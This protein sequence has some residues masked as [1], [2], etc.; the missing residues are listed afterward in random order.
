MIRSPETPAGENLNN[1]RKKN[2]KIF[3]FPSGFAGNK[4]NK[5]KFLGLRGSSQVIRKHTTKM[6]FSQKNILHP[7]K[8]K[9]NNKVSP[10]FG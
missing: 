1:E 8:K 9:I 3:S 5:K 4:R 2:V 6:K 7:K 10:G